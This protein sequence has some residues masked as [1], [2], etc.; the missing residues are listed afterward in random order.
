M[1]E[2]EQQQ[3]QQ[4]YNAMQYQMSNQGFNS[5]GALQ[6]RLDTR[7][8]IEN[9]EIYLRGKD[10]RTVLDEKGKPKQV[11]LWEGERIVNDHGYQAVMRWLNLILNSQVIQGNLLDENYF[12]EYMMN[13]R[14]DVALDL[15]INRIKY[16]IELRNYEGL[17]SGFM[18]CAYLILTRPIFNK[19]REGMNNTTKVVESMQ[20]HPS[21]GWNIP[22]L[23][24]KNNGR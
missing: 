8:V 16:G 11:T 22:F 9:F 3:Q 1:N 23:G 17:V 7:S 20:T 4:N 10:V 13:L 18:N 14:K 19:E 21:G 24:G 2:L 5:A 12:G 6:I 15:M